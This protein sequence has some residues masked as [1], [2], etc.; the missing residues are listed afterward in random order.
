MQIDG[1]TPLWHAASFLL[2]KRTE[3]FFQQL[4]QTLETFESEDI[5]DLRVAS[6]RLR[7]GFAL[8]APCYPQKKINRL[9]KRLKG[10]TRL[11]GKIR[12]D[13]EAILFFTGIKDEMVPE[14]KDSLEMIINAFQSN[15]HKEMDK[16]E[17][18]LNLTVSGSTRRLFNRVLSAPQLFCCE[19]KD[20]DPFSPLLQYADVAVNNRFNMVIE[21]LPE[22]RIAENLE[23]QHQLRIAVKHLRYRIEILSFLFADYYE[24]FHAILKT[25]Q[26]L[27]GKMHDMDVFAE[28]LNNFSFQLSDPEQ[29]LNIL[30]KKREKLFIEFTALLQRESFEMMGKRMR[31]LL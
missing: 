28:I 21:L 23:S 7:E 6:R 1:N 25:Y 12:N 4:D 11:L 16:L 17:E 27:L 9:S 29:L 3:N 13:D 20:F 24:E 14:Q 2:A 15:R 30:R 5:H 19:G 18:G 31:N 22:A 8:F 10:V 26:D